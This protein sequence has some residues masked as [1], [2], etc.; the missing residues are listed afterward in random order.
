MVTVTIWPSCPNRVPLGFARIA[1]EEVE[2]ALA[3]AEHRIVGLEQAQ[4]RYRAR[5]LEGAEHDV[6]G[7]AGSFAGDEWFVHQLGPQ[8][9]EG[10]ADLGEPLLGFGADF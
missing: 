9:L 3:P 8:R 6:V 10:A 1:A 5:P 7:E 4:R 2:H